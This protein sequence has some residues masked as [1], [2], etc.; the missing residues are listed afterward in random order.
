M[1]LKFSHR[2]NTIGTRFRLAVGGGDLDCVFVGDE[3]DFRLL[4][5]LSSIGLDCTSAALN[6][7]E[8]DITSVVGV[9][10]G[11]YIVELCLLILEIVYEIEL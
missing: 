2:S 1:P 3:R 11:H 10:D 8:E 5:D 7:D 9:R 4:D 6:A